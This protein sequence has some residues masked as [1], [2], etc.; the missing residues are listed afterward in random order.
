MLVDHDAAAE[1]AVA[2]LG[3]EAPAC[4]EVLRSWRDGYVEAEH[5][6][7]VA[8][9]VRPLSSLARWMSGAGPLPVYLPEPLR[10]LR[11]TSIAATWAR[12]LRE[13]QASA[14]AAQTF[15][16]RAVAR[17]L[18][19]VLVVQARSV[20]AVDPDVVVIVSDDPD[21]LEG[22]GRCEGTRA[23]VRVTVARTWLTDVWAPGVEWSGADV[24]VHPRRPHATVLRWDRD[25]GGSGLALALGAERDPQANWRRMPAVS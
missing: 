12:G 24:V 8:G 14:A 3:G 11:E 23:I 19:E 13:P 5:D 7:A 4:L 1:A 6:G 18:R 16:D 17:R 25:E 2:A 15:Y 20:G 22:V 21:D 10:R 9:L